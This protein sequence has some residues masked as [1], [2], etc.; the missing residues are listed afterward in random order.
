MLT[1]I[2]CTTGQS[3]PQGVWSIDSEKETGWAINT[4]SFILSAPRHIDL[5]IKLLKCAHSMA[6]GSPIPSSPNK[7]CTE[8]GRAG[9][10]G[11]PCGPNIII[12]YYYLGISYWSQRRILAQDGKGLHT[13][14]KT[15]AK[16]QW[17]LSQRLAAKCRS[18]QNKGTEQPI[19]FISTSGLLSKLLV[20][21][22]DL[23]FSSVGRV[24]VWPI[25]SPRFNT[26]YQINWM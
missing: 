6:A 8:Q 7:G 10:I 5:S 1:S 22:T 13:R 3:S 25:S 16:D 11:S 14:F 20:L 18:L 9:S 4:P 15:A 12:I 21:Q 19:Y 2:P 23:G 26:Q 24:L 17:W